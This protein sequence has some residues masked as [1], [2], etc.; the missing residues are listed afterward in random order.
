MIESSVN[1]IST[2][3]FFFTKNYGKIHNPKLQRIKI[4]AYL[5]KINGG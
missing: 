2:L 3:H 4:K 5:S 1:Y